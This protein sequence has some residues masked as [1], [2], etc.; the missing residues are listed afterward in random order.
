VT[1]DAEV[2]ELLMLDLIVG[3]AYGLAAPGRQPSAHAALA[4]IPLCACGCRNDWN[5]HVEMRAA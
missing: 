5:K 1:R 2:R 3:G 4:N